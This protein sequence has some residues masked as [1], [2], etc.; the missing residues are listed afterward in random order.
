M[1]AGGKI[2]RIEL[3]K[4]TR[5]R[6]GVRERKPGGQF[7][8]KQAKRGDHAREDDTKLVFLRDGYGVAAARHGVNNDQQ[9]AADNRQIQR[10]AK[11]GG[12]NNCR[13]V[14]GQA[15]AEAA[16]HQKQCRAQQARF[17]VEPLSQKFV[18]G[19]NVQPPENRQKKNGDD[20]QRDRH[21]KINLHEAKSAEIT[22]AGSGE[23]GDGAG[24]RGH[25]RKA[26]GEPRR[27]PSPC[28]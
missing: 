18:G 2:H 13:R 12:Q 23:K 26:D 16:L 28:R 11:D 24:L 8:H 20:D 19:I 22:L 15:R 6:Q 3:L 1:N 14:N 4:S 21:A 5:Q 10:P 27:L 25:D 7:R 9:A 17:A